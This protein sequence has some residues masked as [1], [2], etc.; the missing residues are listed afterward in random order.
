MPAQ[1]PDV[2]F[3]KAESDGNPRG[4]SYITI[5]EKEY[6]IRE[7]DVL[8][9]EMVVDIVS[10][11]I[12]AGIEMHFESGLPMRDRRIV[13]QHYFSSRPYTYIM[14]AANTWYKREMDLTNIAGE[15]VK[16][17]EIA[18]VAHLKGTYIACFRDIKITNKGEIQHT[19]YREGEPDI[20]KE[21]LQL[22]FSRNVV[23]AIS[24]NDY[25]KMLLNYISVGKLSEEIA[26]AERLSSIM[27]EL[28][29]EWGE[30][31]ERAK[32]K[33]DIESYLNFDDDTFQLSLREVRTMLKPL[34][35]PVNNFITYL[36]GHAHIDMNWLWVWEETVKVC[37]R[38][39][40]TM[41][42]LM[43][44]FSFF[45]FSQSQAAVYKAVLDYEPALF[46]TIKQY[47]KNGQ[48]EVTASMWVEGDENMAS[49]ESLVRQFLLANRFTK[50]H[51]NVEPEIC[52]QPDLFGHAATMPQILAKCGIKYYYFMRCAKEN[53]SVFKWAAPDGSTVIAAA[54]PN[55]NG[56]I[57]FE[58]Q[59]HAFELFKNQGM[60]DY[61]HCYGVGDHGG[62]PTI[63]DIKRGLEISKNPCLPAMKFSTVEEYFSVVEK[64]YSELPVIRDELQFIFEGCYT[65]HADIKERNR[66]S[67]NILTTLEQLSCFALPFELPYQR[68]FLQGAWERTCFNQFHDILPGSAIHAVYEEAIPPVDA[69]IRGAEKAIDR[70]LRA[71]AANI[72][73]EGVKGTPVF[74]FNPLQWKRSAPVTLTLPLLDGEEALINDDSGKIIPVQYIERRRDSALVLFI[75]E[76]VPPFGYRTYGWQRGRSEGQPDC[77]LACN[78]DIT[79]DN[80]FLKVSI[81]KETGAIESVIDKLDD[82]ELVKTG[83]KFNQLQ[84]LHEE[85]TEM[86][87]WEIGEI[88]AMEML[89]DPVHVELVESG[90][91]RLSVRSVFEW[92]S[93]KFIQYVN[94]YAES[95]D[96]EF[97]TIVDWNETGSRDRGSE[98]L[99]TAFDC[100]AAGDARAYFEIPFGSIERPTGKQ[101]YPAQKW[102]ALAASGRSFVISNENKYGCDSNGTTM[103]LSLLRSSYEPDPLPDRGRHHIR[104]SF[105]SIA[106]DWSPSAATRN[107]MELNIPLMAVA[108]PSNKPVLPK[109]QSFMSI[110]AE[111]IVVSA[112]K[113]SEDDEAFLLRFYEVDGIASACTV[114]LAA[115][116]I[117]VY[118]TDMLERA[119]SAKP[120]DFSKE[121]F[122]VNVTPFEIKTIKIF[123]EP[124]VWEKHHDFPE[125]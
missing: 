94:L 115:P 55:Y 112:F 17:F 68:E 60:K 75:A 35:K 44:K 18:I 26:L 73:T 10:P 95:R 125:V 111:N 113:L 12:Q 63:R 86:S 88:S 13:D 89:N 76:D 47:V 110:D 121:G 65:T 48:W 72:D 32:E 23:T 43:D 64:K 7:G 57:G 51:F 5:S 100:N 123:I 66:K 6:I 46:K 74:V 80:R 16:S 71:I 96:I 78:D 24:R 124:H 29:A 14:D 58:T 8:E 119:I 30:I 49:G 104:Y 20:I 106:G 56:H 69:L 85:P 28:S 109:E 59:N 107:G 34:L 22:G 38:D 3:F 122:T 42:D 84:I 40:R 105:S 19:I 79:L 99:K 25:R 45:R 62:G 37:I 21:K 82:A 108:E 52:W 27:P 77:G 9:F 54:T 91:A 118:E 83:G 53:P 39:F 102:F 50:K 4:Y 1:I 31:I 120:V 41:S 116:V 87:A 15:R 117:G 61:L 97:I 11:V 36:V 93:S 33:L 70:A 98:F 103:R 2:L 101:E 92:K 67:E 90:P 114:T 81:N